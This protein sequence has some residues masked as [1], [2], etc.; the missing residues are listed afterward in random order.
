MITLK[1]ITKTYGERTVLNIPLLTV[2]KG[3]TVAVVGPNGS[4]KSTLLKIVAGIIK[5]DGGEINTEG[6]IYYL[7]Q[8]STPF[9]MSV[10]KNIIFSM[11]NSDNKDRC[12]AEI[13]EELSLT[14][15][16]HKNAK[17]LSG[18]ECQRLCLGRILVNYGDFLLLDEPTSAA[19][20]EGTEIIEK[21]I[22]KYKAETGCGI[23]M[24]THS[25]KQAFILADRIIM[26]NSG[27]IV[28]NGTPEELMKSPRTEW[29]RKFID[30]WK[31]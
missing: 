7:S 6:K 31:I 17:G 13:L 29:G 12:C 11:E 27:E 5:S 18:G 25:P 26:L 21:A 2:K 16:A 19:D 20:I 4:G 3:E 22:E 24:T 9:K 14:P 1:N 15:L 23:I 8:Q 30:M 28:E 10:K